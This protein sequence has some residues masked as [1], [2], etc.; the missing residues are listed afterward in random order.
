MNFD[1]RSLKLAT[2]RYS[3]AYEHWARA[4]NVMFVMLGLWMCHFALIRI[5]IVTLNKITV[6]FV[7]LPLG[8]FL[9][10]QASVAVFLTMLVL[11]AR[12]PASSA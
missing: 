2:R 9:A 4:K 10:I 1:V 6:P 11:F 8:L 5:H 12:K 7:D 3:K